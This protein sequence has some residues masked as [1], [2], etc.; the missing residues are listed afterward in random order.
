MKNKITLALAIAAAVLLVLSAGLYLL[1]DRKAPV[2]NVVDSDIVYEEGMDTSELLK[3]V[4]A[5]DNVDGNVTDQV[6][7][8]DIVVLEGGNRA[9]VTYAV[10]DNSYNLAKYNRIVTYVAAEDQEEPVVNVIPQG[11]SEAEPDT[12]EG[13]Q[14]QLTGEG[15]EDLPLVSTGSPV[16]KLSTHEVRMAVGGAFNPM[17]YIEEIVDDEDTRSD[18]F[19]RVRLEGAYNVNTVGNYELSYYCLDSDG[20]ESNVVKLMLHVE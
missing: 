10:Y 6:R 2:I 3:G 9:Q 1:D 15:Y 20:N 8:I 13:D 12:S 11:P 5:I 17:S 7:I 4:S 19:R 18:L 14:N 16:I